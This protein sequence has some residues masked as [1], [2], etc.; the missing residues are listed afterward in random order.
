[1]ENKVDNRPWLNSYD[2]EV[3]KS[4]EFPEI[5]VPSILERSAERFP[6]QQALIFFGFSMTYQ[7]LWKAVETFAGSLQGL[8]V[9]KETG[10]RYC[11]PTVRTL[12]S[13]TMLF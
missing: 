4:I 6:R 11:F 10:L 9:K 13:P 2:P 12:L 7:K 3:P 8:G 5:L 1:M